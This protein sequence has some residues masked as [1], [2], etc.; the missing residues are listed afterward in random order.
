MNIHF[1]Q[2]EIF[3]APGAYLN[4]AKER[5]YQISFSKVYENEPLPDSADLIN[6]LIVMGGPQSPNTTLEECPHFNAAAEI[7]LI[8]KC[9]SAGKAVVGVCLGSQ[10]IGEALGA[11]VNQSPEKE[12][13]V[14]PITLTKLGTEDEKI[15][16]FGTYLNVGH[17][18]NDMP[19]LTPESKV[20]AFSEGCP[21]QIVSYSNVVYGFQCHM[22]LSTE[23]V[24]LLIESE[25]DL[26]SAS[27]KHKFVQNP[28]TILAY[29]YSE[30]NAKLFEFLDKLTAAYKAQ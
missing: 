11:K 10:L 12:I 22:E 14:F 30:M 15:N 25:D 23:V 6:L 26:A 5:N 9:I 7:N 8:Q 2:H 1:I 13:G 21:V 19:G 27:K 24:S 18:H 29:D 16:H 3:E 28:E 17:W 4:W 20:L